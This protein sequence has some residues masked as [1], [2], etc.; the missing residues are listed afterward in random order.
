MYIFKKRNKC[1]YFYFYSYSYFVLV[2]FFVCFGSLSLLCLCVR[3]VAWKWYM[4][5]NK[6]SC[7]FCGSTKGIPIPGLEPGSIGWKPMMITTYTIWDAR[8]ASK[9]C[10]INQVQAELIIH[11]FFT[12]SHLVCSYIHLLIYLIL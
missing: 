1:F 8:C 10:R 12:F 4:G 5:E 11:F 6:R 7:W 3:V 9:M 2:F